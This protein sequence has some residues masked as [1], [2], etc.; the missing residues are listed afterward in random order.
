MRNKL[1]KADIAMLVI[2]ACCLLF[3]VLSGKIGIHNYILAEDFPRNKIR[4]FNNFIL[5]SVSSPIIDARLGLNDKVSYADFLSAVSMA[6]SMQENYH[7]PRSFIFVRKIVEPLSHDLKT[8]EFR[9]YRFTVEDLPAFFRRHAGRVQEVLWQLY[10]GMRGIS[11]PQPNEICMA[12]HYAQTFWH[13]HEGRPLVAYSQLLYCT[14]EIPLGASLSRFRRPYYFHSSEER[15]QW[16]LFLQAELHHAGYVAFADQIMEAEQE[17][18][19]ELI[20]WQ[21]QKRAYLAQILYENKDSI[22]LLT[23]KNLLVQELTN[24]RNN[25]ALDLNFEKA[26]D[27]LQAID[28]K[29]RSTPQSN[30]SRGIIILPWIDRQNIDRRMGRC[31]PF[32]HDVERRQRFIEQLL[33]QRMT[34]ENI[35]RENRENIDDETKK[36]MRE[37]YE[38]ILCYIR[39]L[40]IISES[41]YVEKNLEE[42]TQLH[43]TLVNNR[44][45]SYTKIDLYVH[46][47]SLHGI[48][49]VDEQTRLDIR[50][51]YIIQRDF[52]DHQFRRQNGDMTVGDV[53]LPWVEVQNEWF[54]ISN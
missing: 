23:L 24:L 8:K 34:Q 39:A 40:A 9:G 14:R 53:I 43:S 11:T 27:S 26:I 19:R 31:M 13:V 20:V 48:K 7:L 21:L 32:E 38:W 50:R 42:M 30:A 2:V 5:Y 6:L 3:L 10:S 54:E 16:F 25:A 49:E 29:V 15:H 44:N 12:W 37:V 36:A 33:A 35:A 1:K 22:S 17:H 47:R 28:D 45:V 51:Y 41:L 52:W 18:Y 46:H 4:V